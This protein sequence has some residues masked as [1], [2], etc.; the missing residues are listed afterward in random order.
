MRDKCAL[1]TG[2]ASGIGQEIAVE[3]ARAGARVAVVDLNLKRAQEVAQ[4]IGGK[5]Y[6]LDVASYSQVQAVV[7]E[8]TKELGPPQ[9]LVN[10]AGVTRDALLVR[11]EE[12]DWDLV[13]SVNLKGAFNCSK[14]VVRGMLRERWGRIINISSVVGYRGNIGQANYAAS[15]AGL[16]GFTKS[17]ARELASRNITVNTIAPGYIRTP[18]TDLLPEEV[19]AQYLKAIPLGRMGE[20]RDVALLCRFLASDEASYITGQVIGVDGGLGI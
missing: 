13:I 10:N 4:E 20:P 18:M 15:K 14:A 16:I 9:I 6:G 1:V 2:G 17:L 8:I 19:K 5:G 12:G 11:M 7:E 3:L